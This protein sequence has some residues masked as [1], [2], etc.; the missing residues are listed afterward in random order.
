MSFKSYR[1]DVEVKLRA[2]YTRNVSAA[3]V[4]LFN[5]V[6]EKIQKAPGRSGRIYQVPGTGRTYVASAPGEP[7]ANRTGTYL[8]AWDFQVEEK[9]DSPV[10]IVGNPLLYAKWLE[11]GTSKMAPR[12]ALRPTVNDENQEIKR[13]LSR[14]IE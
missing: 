5:K 7:P 2:G 4:Y 13:L 3:T 11:L 14:G 12:P 9:N 8:N 6:R 1:R 10:G